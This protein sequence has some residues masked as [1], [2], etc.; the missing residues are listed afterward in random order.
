MNLMA[1][2]CGGDGDRIDGV[3]GVP[4]ETGLIGTVAELRGTVYWDD[5]EEFVSSKAII[6]LYMI[7][8]PN[9]DLAYTKYVF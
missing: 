9:S 4:G 2:R 6:A 7:R 1:R 5:E 8:S 3:I